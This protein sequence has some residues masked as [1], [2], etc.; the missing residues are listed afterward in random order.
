MSAILEM[1]SISKAFPGVQALRDVSLTVQRGEIHGLLGE[2]GAGKSTLMKIL[3]GV[4]APDSGEIIFDGAPVTIA[5]PHQAQQMGIVTIY[6][7]F[8]LVPHMTIAENIFIGRE[9]GGA[10]FLSWRQLRAQTREVMR[11]LG[12]T[13]DPMSTVSGLSVADQQMVEIAR[14]LSMQSKIIVMD[15]PTS[16]LSESEVAQ[17]MEICRD[18]KSKGISIIFITHHLEEVPRICDRITVLRDGQNAGS[19][20]IA[21]VDTDTII[22]MMVGRSAAELFRRSSSYVTQDVI[23]QVRDLYTAKDPNNPNKTALHGISLDLR[24]GE[25]LGIAGLIGAGRTELAR[26]IFGADRFERGEIIFEGRTVQIRSPQDAIRL[27]IGLVPEDRKQQALFLA[28]AVREN[29]SIAVLGRLLRWG[30]FIRFATEREMIGRYRQALNIRMSGH[31]QTVANLSGGNQQKVVIARWLALE[32]QVL[33]VDEPTR[34]IDVA[35]KAE[36]HQL[37]DELAS[38]GIAILMISSELPEIL[39]L[40]DRI[41][42]IREGRLTGEFTRAEATEARLMSAMALETPAFEQR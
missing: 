2:N 33:I 5:T 23:L 25:I 28:Q 7:E 41:L 39:S 18:L 29:L 8:T 27:G 16:A 35:A 19:A 4:Y 1:R 42:T 30:T 38:R 3:A 40:S 14:A 22:Q 6:Q 34:G 9:P 12:I 24:R 20:D 32:P 17:L 36:V 31:D 15:E 26:A 13:L 21:E 37:L 10:G 11:G